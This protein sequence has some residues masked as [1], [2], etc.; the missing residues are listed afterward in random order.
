MINIL[1]AR[2]VTKG[3]RAPA[4]PTVLCKASL[5][6]WVGRSAVLGHVS[7]RGRGLAGA[8]RAGAR[9][10]ARPFHGGRSAFLFRGVLHLGDV[11][12][13]SVLPLDIS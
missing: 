12:R 11:S 4:Q 3:V 10:S 1:I 8:V 13:G 6:V 7:R 2:R 5:H 9:R